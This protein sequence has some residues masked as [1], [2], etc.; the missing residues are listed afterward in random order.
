MGAN[1]MI[2]ENVFSVKFGGDGKKEAVLCVKKVSSI[3]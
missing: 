2:V 1:R 3:G